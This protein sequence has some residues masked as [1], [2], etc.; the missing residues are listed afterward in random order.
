MLKYDYTN[1]AAR[2]L[3]MYTKK[4]QMHLEWRKMNYP[5]H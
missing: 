2:L 4:Q 3:K 5:T 1:P